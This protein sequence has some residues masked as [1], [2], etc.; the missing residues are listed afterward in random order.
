M[1][2]DRVVKNN[3]RYFKQQGAATLVVAVVLLVIVL[4]ISFFTAG[5]VIS[6]KK[7]IGRAHV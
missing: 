1:L 2:T 3:T 6:E 4:G 7:E 5:I